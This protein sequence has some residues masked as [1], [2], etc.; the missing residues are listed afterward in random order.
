MSMP[1]GFTV[2]IP[3]RMA[4]S[5]LPDKPLAD[6]AGLPMVVRVARRAAQSGA[7]RT[8]VAADDERI[9][10]ACRSGL[11]TRSISENAD[12]RRKASLTSSAHSSVSCWR[13]GSASLPMMRAMR[14]R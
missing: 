13:A 1:A 4:S 11:Q 12:W 8:V 7:L 5:R 3:A 10:A 14:S 9:I 2:L 6:I